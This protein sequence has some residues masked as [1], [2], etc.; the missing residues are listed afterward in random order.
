[1]DGSS[2]MTGN[3]RRWHAVHTRSRHEKLV[4]KCL[5]EKG[6]ENFLP[7][8]RVHSQWKDRKKWVDKPLF[9]GYLFVRVPRQKLPVVRQTRG[10]VR[11]LGPDPQ[12]PSIVPEEEVEN[13]RRL[14]ETRVAVDPYPYLRA[15]QL[16]CITR[17]PLRG[18]EGTIIR[19]ANRCLLVVSV[20]LLGRSVAAQISAEAVQGL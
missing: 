4:E 17:G 12:N 8:R 9:P 1:M 6:V 13:I 3:G 19:K 7:L 20:T 18:V 11:V 2:E 5:A 15:G 10:V 14:V 16:V